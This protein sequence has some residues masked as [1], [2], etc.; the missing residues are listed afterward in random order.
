MLYGGRDLGEIDIEMHEVKYIRKYK[1][2]ISFRNE[3]NTEQ[4]GKF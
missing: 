1:L 3:T 2:K 4:R